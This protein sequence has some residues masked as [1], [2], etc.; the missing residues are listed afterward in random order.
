MIQN[1]QLVAPVS[2]RSS[3]A[4]PSFPLQAKAGPGTSQTALC[5]QII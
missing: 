3:L 2:E 1:A 5:A 4:L